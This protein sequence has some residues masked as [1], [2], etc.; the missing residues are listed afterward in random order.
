[1]QRV[2]DIENKMSAFK[3]DSD[4]GRLNRNAG[5]KDVVLSSETI[6][7]LMTAQELS[8]RLEGAFDITVRPLVELW[9]I[10]KKK[11]YI[12]EKAEI[13]E[14][15][16]LVNGKDLILDEKTNSAFLKQIGQCVDLGGIAKGYAADEVKRILVEGGVT[17][18]MINLGGNVITIGLRPDNIPWQVGIQNPLAPTGTYVVKLGINNQT[19]VT[20]GSNQR[21]FI[22][23]GIRYHHILDPRTG[24]PAQ[25]GLL[26]V[27]VVGECSMVLDALTTALFIMGLE[28]GLEL[29]K[30][31][32]AE[33]IFLTEDCKIFATEGLMNK[34]KVE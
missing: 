20:S 23:D 16:K 27:T 8:N 17:S 6:Q 9:G 1:V 12:P 19:I 11:N 10:G 3:A 25:S 34:L 2:F 7:L 13:H 26:S 14:K 31:F 5:Q 4:I 33:A 28:K 18:A 22:K 24:M 30:K 15:S 21:F 32:Q 29:I